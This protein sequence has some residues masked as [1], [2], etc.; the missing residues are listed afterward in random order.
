MFL[1][2]L[3]VRYYYL[4][5]RAHQMPDTSMENAVVILEQ[6]KLENWVVGKTKVVTLKQ[7]QRTCLTD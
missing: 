7:F 2:L 3:C 5:F 4:A 1:L 6:A